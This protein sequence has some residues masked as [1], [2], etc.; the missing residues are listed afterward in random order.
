MSGVE[1]REKLDQLKS[2]RIY[3]IRILSTAK[4]HA[5]HPVRRSEAIMLGDFGRIDEETG[6]FKKEGNIGKLKFQYVDNKLRDAIGQLLD[7]PWKS[8]SSDSAWTVEHYYASESRT[9]V[10]RAVPV[11][12]GVQYVFFHL[13]IVSRY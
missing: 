1:E 6:V 10:Q 9:E 7:N 12:D 5:L 11:G 8:S 3:K 2:T 4:M 13:R